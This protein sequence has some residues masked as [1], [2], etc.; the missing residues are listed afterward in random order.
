[1]IF[2]VFYAFQEVRSSSERM[3]IPRSRMPKSDA[4]CETLG[5]KKE[6]ATLISGCRGSL[7]DS[8]MVL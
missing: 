8:F 5:D 1:M 6:S 4:L 2:N 7:Q 3:R